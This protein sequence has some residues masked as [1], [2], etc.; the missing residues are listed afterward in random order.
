LIF[1]GIFGAA[2]AK[3][4]TKIDRRRIF[5]LRAHRGRLGLTA[6]ERMRHIESESIEKEEEEYRDE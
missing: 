5:G 6:N 2:Q 3:R 4:V 1:F